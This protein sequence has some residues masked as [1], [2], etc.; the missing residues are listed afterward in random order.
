MTH[1]NEYI[2]SQ[3]GARLYWFG[4]KYG[5][6]FPCEVNLLIHSKV[7]SLIND[8]RD[9]DQPLGTAL[10]HAAPFWLLVVMTGALSHVTYT[11]ELTYCSFQSRLSCLGLA[12][13]R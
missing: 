13:E 8:Y 4:F 12:S 9:I 5:N 3:V 1:S 11:V 10:V 6:P 7:V 2:D